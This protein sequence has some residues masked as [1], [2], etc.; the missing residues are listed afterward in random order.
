M[1]IASFPRIALGHLPTPLE[2]APAL[3]SELA[4]PRLFV[5]RDDCTGLA[6]GGNKTR[7]LEY[8]MAD[9]LAKG[10]D[11][12]ITS[13]GTQSNHVR[14]TAAAAARLR[15]ACQCV[16]ANPL[17][18]FQP[19]YLRNGNVLL[20]RLLG[21]ELHV[22]SDTNAATSE[23]V[24]ALARQ[25]QQA[26]RRPYVI[27]VGASDGVGSLGYVNCAGE[28]LSQCLASDIR[29]SH[30]IVATGSAGTHAGL[31]VGLRSLGSTIEVVGVAVS[32]SSVLKERKV[33]VVVQQIA[34]LIGAP[35][36][37]VTDRDIV[38]RDA[39]V[40]QGYGIPA[41]ETFDAIRMAARLE[42]LILDPVYT[43]KAMA[44]LIRLVRTG[45]LPAARDII[46]MHTGGSPAA[47]AYSHAFAAAEGT[48]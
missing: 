9:A 5:K 13:G 29:P 48:Q 26:G 28:I 37:L 24:T 31:L 22:A 33:R 36:D 23:M 43:G 17:Q 40:G 11:L 44:G 12:I 19:E 18:S 20:D 42:S 14:Q 27:P 30:I 38:V 15:L 4:G 2:Y 1:D 32:E 10:A 41:P 8:A 45:V 34:A 7:K 21:A 6:L 25:A 3:T 47:F 39:H 46:F 35:S 16:V